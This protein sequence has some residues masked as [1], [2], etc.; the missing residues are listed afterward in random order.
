MFCGRQRE[1]IQVCADEEEKRYISWR[2]ELVGY[3]WLEYNLLVL[4]LIRTP[5]VLLYGMG[6]SMGS[7]E[8]RRSVI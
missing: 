6:W 4:L 1:E 3:N 5:R 8:E 2:F 7:I